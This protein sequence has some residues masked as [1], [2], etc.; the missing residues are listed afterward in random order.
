MTTQLNFQLKSVFTNDSRSYPIDPYLSYY[1]EIVALDPLINPSAYTFTK[2]VYVEGAPMG[3]DLYPDF[4]T[5]FAATIEDLIAA[6]TAQINVDKNTFYS[7]SSVE[8]NN[9]GVVS[10][11]SGN[12]Q[13]IVDSKQPINSVLTELADATLTTDQIVMKTLDGFDTVVTG[14][15]GLGLLA[16]TDNEAIQDELNTQMEHVEGLQDEIDRIDGSLALKADLVGGFIRIDQMPAVAIGTIQTA[17][18]QVAMLGLTTQIGDVVVRSDQNKTYM[19]NGGA[20]GTMADFTELLFPSASVSSVFGRI[21][22]VIASLGD[23]AASLV[24]NDSSVSGT[25]VKD[26]LQN[27]AT[28]ISAKFTLPGGGTSSQYLRGDG[29]LATFPSL[30][31]TK[32]TQSTSLVSS[33]SGGGTQISSTKSSQVRHT[34]SSSATA[35]IGGAAT[36]YVVL[37]TAATNSATAGDWTEIGRVGTENTV[38]LAIV[39]NSISKGVGMLVADLDPGEW[40]RLRQLGTGTHSEAVLSGSKTIFG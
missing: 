1:Y 16:C 26:A 12:G 27:L 15:G 19:H 20:A 29:T 31:R 11:F 4:E 36:S 14:E 2:E 23:Y 33:T 30:A 18:T 24:S 39:L 17:A 8:Y 32:S 21:G 35:T 3:Y 6:A 40:Y 10:E 28:A 38:T 7:T 9:P 13:V 25:T 37:E 22:T 34:V 5:A